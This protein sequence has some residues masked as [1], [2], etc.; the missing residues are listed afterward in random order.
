M[1]KK[2]EEFILNEKYDKNIR[3]KLTDIGISDQRELDKQ[4]KLAKSGS[5]GSYLIERGDKFTFGMLNAIFKDAIKAKKLGNIKKGIYSIIPS[6]LP[7]VLVPFYP[8]LAIIGSIF[9][10]SKMFH[11]IFEPI[12]N[13]IN[14]QS[15]YADFLKKMIDVYMLI[16]EGEFK[17]K[18]RFTRA[19]VVQDRLID[20]IK[21][22]I[23]EEFSIYLSEKMSTFEEDLEVPPHFIENELKEYLNLN[24]NV[25]PKIQT[26]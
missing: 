13:Y 24:Y 6:A 1:I 26:K 15:K 16:P 25:E 4:V 17:V 3:K 11:K 21:P 12:F 18:D 2:Y 9:G 5:L 23:L 10:A 20:S 14:P 8:T 19:F 22:E 7:L